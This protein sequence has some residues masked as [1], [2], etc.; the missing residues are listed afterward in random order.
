MEEKLALLQQA[1]EAAAL[2]GQTRLLAFILS[3][4]GYA[5]ADLG[6]WDEAAAA[7]AAC[8]R[9]AWDGSFWREWF[10]GL[11]NL[12]RTLAHR[13][14]PE[15]AVRLMAFADGFYAMRFGELGS[16]DRREARRTRRLVRAQLGRPRELAL[17][18]EGRALGLG[19]AM[20][21][22]LRETAALAAATTG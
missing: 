4:Q 20:Q 10:Y 21:L 5:L 7:Y 2:R 12:P 9:T 22:A 3:V 1:R 6:R 16:S 13:R 14:R 17:W 8:L 18:R 15:A 11:W 19:E